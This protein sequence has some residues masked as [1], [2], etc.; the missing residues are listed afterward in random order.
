MKRALFILLVSAASGALAV[1]TIDSATTMRTRKGRLT[2]DYVLSGGPAVVTFDVTTNGVSILDRI[3]AVS[4]DVNAVFEN[5]SHSFSWKSTADLGAADVALKDLQVKVKAWPLDDKPDYMV[6][7]LRR[8]DADCVRYHESTNSLPGGILDDRYRTRLLVMKRVHAR[9]IEWTM[10]TQGESGR[11]A[12]N[13]KAHAVTLDHDYYLGVFEL[14]VA[15]RN[16]FASTSGDPGTDMKPFRNVTYAGLRGSTDLYPAAPQGGEL[17]TLNDVT[18]LDFDL[19]SEA[20]WEF[21]AKC[22]M[23]EC[24]WPNGEW[25]TGDNDDPGLNRMAR[26][27]STNEG[28]GWNGSI[29]ETGRFEPSAWGFYDMHGNVQEWCLDWFEA[30][31]SDLGGAVNA[32]GAN[33]ADG[34]T[35]GSTRVLRGGCFASGYG[36]VRAAYRASSNPAGYHSE[37]GVRLCCRNGLK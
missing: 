18:G 4:G 24:R 32:N 12:A 6:V 29:T 16:T 31:I 26:Y 15:Q 20:Q 27:T 3:S 5:G 1:P 2:V 28:G 19:P 21:A 35:A 17:K 30:D 33:L 10:G 34:V 8:K 7:D 14:T 9:G 13:E 11:T 23:H 37:N 36:S 22:L 25:M